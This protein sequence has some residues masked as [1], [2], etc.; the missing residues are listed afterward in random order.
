[1]PDIE[2][3]EDPGL[4]RRRGEGALVGDALARPA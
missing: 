3:L 4:I 2:K 1:L